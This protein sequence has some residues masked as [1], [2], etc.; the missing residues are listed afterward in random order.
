MLHGVSVASSSSNCSTVTANHDD[1]RKSNHHVQGGYLR[2]KLLLRFLGELLN[3][4]LVQAQEYGDMLTTLCASYVSTEHLQ[5]KQPC[6][7][8]VTYM[9]LSAV[10]RVGP[11]LSKARIVTKLFAPLVE[12]ECTVLLFSRLMEVDI[13]EF[14]SG[15]GCV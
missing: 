11:S 5:V 10:L 8:I 14:T 13:S 6:R 15:V 3:C 4:G 2:A 7:D 12:V 1:R 9:V